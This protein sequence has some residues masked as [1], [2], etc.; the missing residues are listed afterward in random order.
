RRP[1][2]A[3]EGAVAGGAPAAVRDVG[4]RGRCAHSL[5]EA[6]GDDRPVP[7]TPSEGRVPCGPDQRG[8]HR[9][10]RTA[11]AVDPQQAEAGASA[12]LHARR[13]RV[14]RAP[15]YSLAVAISPG[16]SVR[17]SRLRPGIQGPVPAWRIEYRD[18]RR[19][20]LLEGLRLGA[21]QF[22]TAPRGTVTVY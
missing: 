18:V 9:L 4:V 1:G 13:E 11:S 5:S 16:A 19:H 10:Q 2:D 20:L 21:M 3:F 6:D 17:V 8:F 12:R 22:P 15:R 14:S 7:E